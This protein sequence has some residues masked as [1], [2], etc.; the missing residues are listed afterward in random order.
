MEW[1]LGGDLSQED[2]EAGSPLLAGLKP[3]P[4]EALEVRVGLAVLRLHPPE[5][6]NQISLG[7]L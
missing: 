7:G 4:V 1:W 5:S 2:G 3:P 6:A